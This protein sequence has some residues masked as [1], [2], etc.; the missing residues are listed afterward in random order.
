MRRTA[1]LAASCVAMATA[2]SGCSFAPD[3]E[4]IDQRA[5]E[6]FDG[7]V[8]SLDAADPAVLR[9]LEVLEPSEQACE[10]AGY[11]QTS[12]TARGTL[13]VAADAGAAS[14][15]LI[16]AESTFARDGYAPAERAGAG[17][18]AWV[19]DDGVLVTTTDA[20]PVLVV[21]VFTPCVR[22]G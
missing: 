15:L 8:A 21:A 16:D 4:A 10:E 9:T 5:Q 19:S 2:L 18:R 3:A 6:V 22:T 20:S 1:A 17:E 12:R 7:I 11:T 14:S 13:A